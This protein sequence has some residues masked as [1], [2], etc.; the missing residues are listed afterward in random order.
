M[1]SPETVKSHLKDLYERF[2]L[3]HVAPSAK[4]AEL[5]QRAIRFGMVSRTQ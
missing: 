4:R 5:A 3:E 1:L 2:G